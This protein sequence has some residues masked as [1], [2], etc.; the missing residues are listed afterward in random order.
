MRSESYRRS[1]PYRGRFAP[2]PTGP[3]HLGSLVTAVA[4][5]ADARANG[6][7]WLVRI[8]DIDKPRCVP[9]A[10]EAILRTLESFGL[11]WDGEV[12]YQSARRDRY[13]AAIERLGDLA[14]PCAC[15][16]QDRECRCRE[17]LNGRAA[18][19]IRVADGDDSFV[20]RRADGLYAYMLAVVVDDAE[21]GIT[22]I[23]RGAD[24]LDSTPRQNF[25]R[26]ALG[27]PI[28]KYLHVPLVL[29]D[30]GE[31]LS[32]QNRAPAVAPGDTRALLAAIEFL[33][34]TPPSGSDPLAWAA[35]NWN[36]ARIMNL[37]VSPSR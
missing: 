33:G 5:W 28:P 21:S 30:D 4:S 37:C 16:R 29:G 31:K 22:D 20:V 26:R 15:T 34:H 18:R 12:V 3:L 8:E 6:G 11:H 7:E 14:Y 27:Y 35:E 17:G 10:D 36:P 32:K 24:L 23:V 25:L 1:M 19:S 9:G 2:S 13:A